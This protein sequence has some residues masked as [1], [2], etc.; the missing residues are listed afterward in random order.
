[1]IRSRKS[2]K[3]AMVTMTSQ[4]QKPTISEVIS[5]LGVAIWVFVATFLSGLITKGVGV[6]DITVAEDAVNAAISAG[7]GVLGWE[8]AHWARKVKQ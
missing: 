6:W 2:E 5:A 4:S 7:L 3:P 8:I 1:M